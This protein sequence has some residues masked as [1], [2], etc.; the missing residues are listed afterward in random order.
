MLNLYDIRKQNSILQR[1]LDS[2]KHFFFIWKVKYESS[3]IKILLFANNTKSLR[4]NLNN[5]NTEFS[6][7]LIYARL[8]GSHL[9]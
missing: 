4:G 5:T 7:L 2:A 8:D 9:D 1:F 3:F 6:T